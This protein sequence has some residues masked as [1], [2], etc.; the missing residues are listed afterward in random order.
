[1]LALSCTPPDRNT[2]FSGGRKEDGGVGER[3]VMLGVMSRR[4]GCECGTGGNGTVSWGAG[5]ASAGGEE[6]GVP[7]STLR[8][9]GKQLSPTG[10]GG[11]GC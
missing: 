5:A 8:A 9:S 7:S 11:S 3:E 10:G 4:R 1:M 2:S 6:A